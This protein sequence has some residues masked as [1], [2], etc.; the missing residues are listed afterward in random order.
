MNS[1]KLPRLTCSTKLQRRVLPY[2]SFPHAHVLENA[3]QPDGSGDQMISTE[4]YHF[5][6]LEIQIFVLECLLETAPRIRCRNAPDIFVSPNTSALN[7]TML[8]EMGSHASYRAA[9]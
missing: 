2:T 1:Q 8:N 4:A 6:F 7:Q 9:S 5:H 3:R